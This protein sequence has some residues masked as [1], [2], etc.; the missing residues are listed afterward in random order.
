MYEM[1]SELGQV[2]GKCEEMTKCLENMDTAIADMDEKGIKGKECTP[3]LLS[4]IS[5][6]TGGESLASNIQL[7]FNNAAVGTEI[8]KAYCELTK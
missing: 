8:A 5:E 2:E 4:R 7:V 6:I 3:F 1:I